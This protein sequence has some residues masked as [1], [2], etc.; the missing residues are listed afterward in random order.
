MM[1]MSFKIHVTLLNWGDC[2]NLASTKT[3]EAS[4]AVRWGDTGYLFS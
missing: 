4:E 1:L 3:N 2:T